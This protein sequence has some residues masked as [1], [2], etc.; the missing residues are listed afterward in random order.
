[1]IYL[2]YKILNNINGKIYIGCHKTDDI[3]DGYMGSGKLISLAI[4]KYGKGNFTKEILHVFDNAEDMFSM[5]SKLVNTN[6]VKDDLTYNLKEGGLGGFDHINNFGINGTEKGVERRRQLWNTAWQDEWRDRQREGIES[7]TEEKITVMCKRRVESI[8]KTYGSDAFKTFTGKKH[9]EESKQKMRK[10]AK[11]KHNGNKNSQYGMMW[12]YNST[13][14]ENK[15]IPKDSPIP[16]D[17][18]KGR[19][20]KF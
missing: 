19:K 8:R 6:F 13:L 3:D 4:K 17:W 2:I 10:S 18:I 9:S 20:I 5:E 11:G 14:K 12:I 1:M 7:M 16:K 15:K